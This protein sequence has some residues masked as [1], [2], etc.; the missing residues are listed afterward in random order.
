MSKE[1]LRSYGKGAAM[2]LK[3][4]YIPGTGLGQNGK[5]IVEPIMPELRKRGEGIKVDE[6]QKPNMMQSLVVDAWSDS[7]DE[8][9]DEDG[10]KGGSLGFEKSGIFKSEYDVPELFDLVRELKDVNIS[11]PMELLEWIDSQS[12]EV[13]GSSRY[14]PL[15]KSLQNIIKSARPDIA[16]MK[17]LE[18]ESNRIRAFNEMC[19]RDVNLLEELCA[20]FEKDENV[21]VDEILKIENIDSASAEIKADIM[22]LICSR[23]Q[24][25]IEQQLA[26]CNVGD[27]FELGALLDVAIEYLRLSSLV[28]D[29]TQ[30]KVVSDKLNSENVV[31]EFSMLDS[32]ILNPIILK[33]GKF[34]QDEWQV[35]KFNL[36][37]GIFEE[38]RDSNV[39]SIEVLDHVI[40]ENIIIPKLLEGVELC[41]VEIADFHWIVEWLKVLPM[42]YFN[43]ITEHIINEK[44]C[45]YL[46]GYSGEAGLDQKM[47]HQVGIKYWL[48]VAQRKDLAHNIEKSLLYYT[49][50]SLRSGFDF[51][52]ILK[53]NIWDLINDENIRKI[54]EFINRIKEF[55]LYGYEDVLMNEVMVPYWIG[56]LQIYEDNEDF[57]GFLRQMSE[58]F[59]SLGIFD[60]E[61]NFQCIIKGVRECY[62]HNNFIHER[63]IQSRRVLNDFIDV[64]TLLKRRE[65]NWKVV[66]ENCQMKRTQAENVAT[67]GAHSVVGSIK[68]LVF[69]KCEEANIAIVPDVQ[70]NGK[71]MYVIERN[72]E[73]LQ[74]YFGQKVMYVNYGDAKDVPMSLYELLGV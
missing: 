44:Y 27:I 60:H 54:E 72:G 55:Q 2:L 62:E 71:Q 22:R 25:K 8:I 49:V 23:L 32:V 73:S 47:L 10:N 20:L 26:V 40:V 58:F 41:D 3:M 70:K 34:Y 24:Q 11:V 5:G 13:L 1:L 9:G 37:V 42:K 4:G 52:A 29:V 39:F 45:T 61:D 38:V 7:E 56:Y 69:L 68:D 74:V 12:A 59:S 53:N 16:K 15:R 30:I 67:P 21:N 51:D 6:N 63:K 48:D 57:D 35:D 50:K 33:I 14:I 18:F 65:D 17:Y 66:L 46:K 36:G 28:D 64:A 31:V 19:A 43:R